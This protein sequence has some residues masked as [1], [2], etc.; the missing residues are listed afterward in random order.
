[1]LSPAVASPVVALASASNVSAGRDSDGRASER[2]RRREARALI[3][4]YHDEQLR[5]L[6][7]HVVRRL[8]GLMPARSMPSSWTI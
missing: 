1:M 5:V 7:E 4:A 6:L 2:L 8:R 3:G